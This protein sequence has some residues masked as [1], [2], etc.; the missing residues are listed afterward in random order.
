VHDCPALDLISPGG[1]L[2]FDPAGM[3]AVSS[4]I[5]RRDAGKPVRPLVR[6]DREC[7]RRGGQQ[8]PPVER[9]MRR[10]NH[11]CDHTETLSGG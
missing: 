4:Q 11:P 6:A 9:Q 2:Y 1:R 5:R 3:P 8:T 7:S 10:T